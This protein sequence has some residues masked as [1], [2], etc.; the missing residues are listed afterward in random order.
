MT[1]ISQDEPVTAA[2][3]K[4]HIEEEWQALQAWLATL[5]DAQLTQ[6]TDAEGWTVKD[7]LAHLARWQTSL[8]AILHGQTKREAM[9]IDEVTWSGGDD[10]INAVLRQRDLA[11]SYPEVGQLLRESHDHIIAQLHSMTDADVQRP[12]RDFQPSSANSNPIWK[13]IV[14]DTFMHYREHQPWMAAIAAQG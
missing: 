10:A 7:H 2:N 8:L 6:L 12:F 3:L 4:R 5:S 13:Q 14:G 11:L 9:N 1:N